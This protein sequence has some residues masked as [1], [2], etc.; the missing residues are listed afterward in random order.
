MR[1]D[2][3]A[4]TI[5]YT[6]HLG[7]NRLRRIY[8]MRILFDTPKDGDTKVWLLQWWDRDKNTMHY[9]RM[10]NIKEWEGVKELAE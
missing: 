10:D 7:E 9:T 3:E 2:R 8:P 5:T 1:P 4:V 6:N